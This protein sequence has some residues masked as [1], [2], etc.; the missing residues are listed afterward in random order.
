MPSK[1]QVQRT[2]TLPDPA[3]A[4]EEKA[5]PKDIHEHTVEAGRGG[6]FLL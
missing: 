1:N 6:K 4:Q 5:H 3:L 2:F